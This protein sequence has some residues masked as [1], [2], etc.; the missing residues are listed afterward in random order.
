MSGDEGQDWGSFAEQRG[1]T[2]WLPCQLHVSPQPLNKEVESLKTELSKQAL[3]ARGGRGVMKIYPRPR[4]G[5]YIRPEQEGKVFV[6]LGRVLIALSLIRTAV[7]FSGW[8]EC[9][10]ECVDVTEKPNAHL[11]VSTSI[12]GR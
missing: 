6:W 2:P 8:E 9:Q 1:E 10:L 4:R 12:T 7:F 5:N 11:A 3:E